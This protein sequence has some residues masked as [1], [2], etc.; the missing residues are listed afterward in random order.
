MENCI[1][2]FI[3]YKS[4]SMPVLKHDSNLLEIIRIYFKFKEPSLVVNQFL[5]N[6]LYYFLKCLI[7]LFQDYLK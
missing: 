1:I 6:Q 2:F 3:L 7:I 5:N 4:V